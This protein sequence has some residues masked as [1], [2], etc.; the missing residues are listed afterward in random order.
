MKFFRADGV[1]LNETLICMNC[2]DRARWRENRTI[3]N[4]PNPRLA[5]ASLL[6][7]V[8]INNANKTIPGSRRGSLR[9]GSRQAS[10]ASIPHTDHSGTGID[11][12]DDPVA[13]P[14]WPS[15]QLKRCQC[16]LAWPHI[17]FHWNVELMDRNLVNGLSVYNRLAT[18]DVHL[19]W[20]TFS[21][22]HG[23]TRCANEWGV[24]TNKVDLTRLPSLSQDG[25]CL[26]EKFNWTEFF[27]YSTVDT[28]EQVL[29]D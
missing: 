12:P 29:V 7:E 18:F 1:H 3:F 19:S 22:Y 24:K 13:S 2:D 5:N 6:K 23:D 11:D 8:T 27:F 14:H 26:L 17:I 4:T 21:R 16:P 20:P 25:V 10:L 15:N 28:S 9:N